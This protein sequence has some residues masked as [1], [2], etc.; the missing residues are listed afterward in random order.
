MRGGRNKFGPMYKRDRA[1]KLQVLRQR[2]VFHHSTSPAGLGAGVSL[3]GNTPNASSSNN[4]NNSSSMYS[5]PL[6][7]IKQEIQIPQVTSM[8][9]SPDS[10]PSPVLQLTSQGHLP[11]SSSANATSSTSGSASNNQ[12]KLGQVVAQHTD[13]STGG[14]QWQISTSP[15]VIFYAPIEISVFGNQSREMAFSKFEI[16]G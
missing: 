9:S 12:H 1:R 11:S 2:Q 8:T 4:T 7:H 6:Q 5:S 10:S 14:V 15:K 3:Y 13:P 16:L